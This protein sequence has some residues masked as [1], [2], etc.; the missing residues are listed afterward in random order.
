MR[1]LAT[2]R[3]ALRV[4]GEHVLRLS[5]LRVPDTELV[6]LEEAMHSSAVELLVERAAAAGARAFDGSDGALLARIT[7]QIDGIPLAIEL[8]AARLGVQSISD[9]ALRLNDHMRLYPSTRE[10]SCRDTRRSR[11]RSTGARRS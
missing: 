7:R 11:Q 5:P 9:L 6:R 10:P 4:G 8:V 2:S 1:I 3:E